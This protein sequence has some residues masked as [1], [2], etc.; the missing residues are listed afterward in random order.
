MKHLI[1]AMAM[2]LAIS[3][4]SCSKSDDDPQPE[5][6]ADP[7]LI[8]VWV[9]NAAV[10]T[11]EISEAAYFKTNDVLFY[12]DGKWYHGDY[13]IKDTDH[14]AA[15]VCEIKMDDF[16]WFDN[17]S[18]KPVFD[19]VYYDWIFRYEI[20]GKNLYIERGNRSMTLTKWE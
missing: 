16:T 9:D 14:F 6:K 17:Y 2:M 18:A 19:P 5:A 8:G 13:T 15:K 20:K 4:M 7:A 11:K 3:V 12:Y 1:Y 10:T